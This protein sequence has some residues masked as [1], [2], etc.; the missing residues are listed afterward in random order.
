MVQRILLF[1]EYHVLAVI[2]SSQ[3]GIKGACH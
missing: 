2:A 1:M 3:R